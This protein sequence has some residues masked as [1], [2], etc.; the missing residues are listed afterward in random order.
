ML[1]KGTGFWNN[2]ETGDDCILDEISWC[3]SL[4]SSTRLVCDTLYLS[5]CFSNST[6]VQTLHIKSSVEILL[7]QI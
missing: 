5:V 3:L 6:V 7:G 2:D 1:K 4:Q